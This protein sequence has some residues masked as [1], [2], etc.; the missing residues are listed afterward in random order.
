MLLIDVSIQDS[1]KQCKIYEVFNLPVPHGD[2]SAKY[3]ISDKYIGIS[4]HETQVV[5]ITKQQ[6]STCVHA[7]GQ[8]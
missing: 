3:E 1:A 6:Y 2:V 4:Y 7:N 8:F 5:V